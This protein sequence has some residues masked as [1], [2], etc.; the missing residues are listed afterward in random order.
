MDVM[1]AVRAEKSESVEKWTNISYPRQCVQG[2]F[3][4]RYSVRTSCYPDSYI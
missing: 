3:K 4:I 1:G 2:D